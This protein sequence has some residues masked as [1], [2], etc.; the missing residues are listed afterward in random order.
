M[1]Q[2]LF[3]QTRRRTFAALCI[4]LMGMQLA[5]F[6]PGEAIAAAIDAVAPKDASAGLRAA[7]SQGVDK[8]IGLLG[9]QNGFLNNPQYTIPLPPALQKADRALRMVGLSADADEL[10]A[11]M[12]HAAEMAVADARPVFKQ[13]VQR[14]SIA[15][16]KSILTGGD[17]AATD[18]FK[19]TTSAQLMTRFKPIVAKAT[20]QLRL[21]SLYDQYAGKAAQF[22]LIKAEDANL[23]DYVTARALDSLFT[24]IATEEVAIR[25]DP[26]GQTSSLL[27]KVFGALQH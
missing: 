3:S 21:G 22:G 9:A 14:M 19:Q 7:I 2:S 12:N 18:Y 5:A 16:A 1:P 27:K 11:S 24:A 15:D 10:K 25:K 23:N 20:A 13:A 6:F 26:L 17:T 8:A 4:L